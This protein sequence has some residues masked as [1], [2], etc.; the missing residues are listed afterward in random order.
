MNAKVKVTALQTFSHGN[1]DAQQGGTYRLN[2]G[3]ADELAKA[4]FVTLDGGDEPAAQTQVDQ[5][6]QKKQAGDVVVDAPGE[7][8]DVLGDKAAPALSNK[9]A[10]APD[11]KAPAKRK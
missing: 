11:N 7:D 10:E 5:P 9:M 6:A 2:K 1:V 8:D 4:G 3:D